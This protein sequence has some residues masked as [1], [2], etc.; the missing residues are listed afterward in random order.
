MEK[1]PTIAG[2]QFEAKFCKKINTEPID[3]WE[4]SRIPIANIYNSQD[5]GTYA[6]NIV[7]YI[8]VNIKTIKSHNQSSFSLMS[9]AI[10]STFL[11]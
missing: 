10:E 9:E 5:S 7:I 11:L 2:L 4:T 6:V 8:P 1:K 3:T